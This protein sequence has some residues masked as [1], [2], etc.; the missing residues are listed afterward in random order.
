MLMPCSSLTAGDLA[1]I[2]HATAGPGEI[3]GALRMLSS[4]AVAKFSN[5]ISDKSEYHGDVYVVVW[6]GRPEIAD[7]LTR[8]RRG[9]LV[10]NQAL[11][12]NAPLNVWGEDEQFPREDWRYEVTNDDTNLGYWEWVKSMRVVHGTG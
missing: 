12:K 10:A 7:V 3:Q 6:P 4:A 5:F 8:D 9:V 1:E 11:D 2:A